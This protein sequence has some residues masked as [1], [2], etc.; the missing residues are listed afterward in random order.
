MITT[1]I[2]CVKCNKL[3][4]FQWAV[5]I[6][7]IVFSFSLAG[8]VLCFF[9]LFSSLIL[10]TH[11]GIIILLLIGAFALLVSNYV[12]L[13]G[14]VVDRYILERLQVSDSKG[15]TGNNRTTE[16]FDA[17]YDKLKRTNAVLW[18]VGY[19]LY[20]KEFKGGNAGYKVFIV[21]YG[22]IGLAFTFLF[23]LLYMLQH[24]T[25]YILILFSLYGL[26]FIQRAYPF[27]EAWLIPYICSVSFYHKNSNY[28]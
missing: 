22:Y 24:K 25:K 1:F 26:A 14:T 9:L 15:I 18:G 12:K 23:Y 2:L 10:N 19:D 13:E 8:Y 21:Q 3:S 28:D 4:I 6:S 27:W 11:R 16:D 17:Y 20:K 7:S 5:L